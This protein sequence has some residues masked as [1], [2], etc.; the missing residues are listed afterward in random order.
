MGRL[1]LFLK[2][3]SLASRVY[4]EMTKIV[5]RLSDLFVRGAGRL[6]YLDLN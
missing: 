3:I 1:I 5:F 2:Y 6:I 4:D